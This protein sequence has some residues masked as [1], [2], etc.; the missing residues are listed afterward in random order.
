MKEHAKLP[1]TC[2][3]NEALGLASL[4]GKHE[5]VLP[6]RRKQD[7]KIVLNKLLHFPKSV[8]KLAVLMKRPFFEQKAA[9]RRLFNLH[10]FA[11]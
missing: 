2:K 10:T 1:K 6:S 5:L 3:N 9:P 4:N 11:T 7:L 8:W